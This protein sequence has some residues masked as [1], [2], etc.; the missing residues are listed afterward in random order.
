MDNNQ[1]DIYQEGY[2]SCVNGEPEL[3]NPYKGI[4]AEYWSDGWSDG[5]EDNL[6]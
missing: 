2:R 5:H 4:D 6:G 3:S 1:D